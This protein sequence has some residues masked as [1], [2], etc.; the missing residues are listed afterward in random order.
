MTVV[1]TKVLFANGVVGPVRAAA[2]FGTLV[3]LRLSAGD[4]VPA[5]GY[6]NNNKFQK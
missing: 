5:K 2:S 6:Y 1:T 4:Q 3:R